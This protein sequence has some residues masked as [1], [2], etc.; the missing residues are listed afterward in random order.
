M[1]KKKKFLIETSILPGKWN[2]SAIFVS[3]EENYM[4]P[5]RTITVGNCSHA[6]DVHTGCASKIYLIHPQIFG[7]GVHKSMVHNV[8][9]GRE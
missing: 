4:G 1:K 9:W 3:G 5:A 2:A 7:G 6:I 8:A